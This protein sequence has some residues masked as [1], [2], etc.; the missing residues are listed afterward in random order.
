MSVKT[1]AATAEE[2]KQWA[3]L[4]RAHVILVKGWKPEEFRI[5]Y[6]T[7][8]ADAPLATFNTIHVDGIRD[9]KENPPQGFEVRPFSLQVFVQTEELRA[10]DDTDEYYRIKRE[11][12]EK[13]G[14]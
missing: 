14:K 7:T 12:Q 13:A 1:R 9:L 8:L 3:A 6:V 5:Y 11:A 2:K 10:F 4:V